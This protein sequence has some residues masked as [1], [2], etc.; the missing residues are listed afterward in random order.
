MFVRIEKL[1]PEDQLQQLL[2]LIDAGEFIDG[3]DSAGAPARAVKH[4]R[5][6]NLA[7][8][9]GRE[10][11]NDLLSRALFTHPQVRAAALP[12]RMTVPLVSRYES[13]MEYGWHMDN[14]IMQGTGS[15]VRADIACTLFLS[16]PDDYDGGELEISGPAGDSRIKLD[17]GDAFLY[18][19][20]SRHRVAKIRSGQRVAAIVWLQSMV[21]DAGAREVLYELELAY[22]RIREGDPDSGA[23]RHLQRAQANLLR[24]WAEV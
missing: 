15:P 6:L 22:R 23:I 11:L 19:A 1:L 21:A 12:R 7:T 16:R 14:A 13:G 24:R 8:L 4:N 18:P 17:Q 10:A 5:Q 9:P 20:T 3:G 2:Q